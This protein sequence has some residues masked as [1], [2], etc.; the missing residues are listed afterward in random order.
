V[1]KRQAKRIAIA[2]NAS[3]I[4]FGADT[5]SVTELLSEKDIVRFQEAQTEM[6]WNMLRS[7]GFDHPMQAHEIMAAVLGPSG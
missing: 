3:Y 4:L 1:N 2:V 7:A 5:D 6:A